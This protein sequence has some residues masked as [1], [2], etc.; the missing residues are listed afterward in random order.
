[1]FRSVIPLCE[2]L[3]CLE[4]AAESE[5]QELDEIVNDLQEKVSRTC[6]AVE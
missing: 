1:M 5:L 6:A 4:A 2:I 3:V